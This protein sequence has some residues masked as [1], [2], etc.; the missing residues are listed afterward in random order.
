MQELTRQLAECIVDEVMSA[1]A[2]EACMA[3]PA[4]GTATGKRSLQTCV[5]TPAPRG[6]KLRSGSFFPGDVTGHS[7]PRWSRRAPRER[8]P[9]RRDG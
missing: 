8:A 1:E 2:D 5:G 6:L 4:A 7:R 9:A 3:A